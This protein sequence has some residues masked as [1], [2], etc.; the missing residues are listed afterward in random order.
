MILKQLTLKLFLIG[1]IVFCPALALAFNVTENQT[2]NFTTPVN[3][4]SFLAPDYE[5]Q[6]SNCSTTYAWPDQ[7]STSNLVYTIP[8][9]NF[10]AT[11]GTSSAVIDTTWTFGE[12]FIAFLLVFFIGYTII[13][14]VLRF[15]FPDR[16]KIERIN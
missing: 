4:G 14:D 3:L 11:T 8:Y 6:K 15:F 10:T 9:N 16:V 5:Y 1:S 7:A 2:C 12:L 13:K